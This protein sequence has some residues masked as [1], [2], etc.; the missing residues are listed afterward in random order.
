MKS[1]CLLMAVLLSCGASTASAACNGW[2]LAFL[3]STR[4]VSM[5]NI[6]DGD[7]AYGGQVS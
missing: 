4:M 3:H 2:K 5:T 6:P 7:S 1:L